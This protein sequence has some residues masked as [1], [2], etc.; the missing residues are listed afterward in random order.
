MSNI[1]NKAATD[2]EQLEETLLGP[3]YPY[4]KDINTPKDLGFSAGGSFDDLER[5]VDGLI[6][7][8]DVL[9]TGR[10]NASRTGRPLGNK[11]FL[12]TGGKCKDVDTGKLVDRYMYIN[13]VPDGDIP[14]ISEAMGRSF[15][16]FE[17]L[18][19]GILT[20]LGKINPMKFLQALTLGENPPCKEVTLEVINDNNYASKESHHILL[21]D[22]AQAEGFENMNKTNDNVKMPNDPIIQLYYL[23]LGLVIIY[24]LYCLMNKQKK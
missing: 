18:L 2:V 20:D 23:S 24:I 13:N 10:G 14:F 5:D 3:T 1:F 11:F 6:D 16:S 4:W 15:N 7:Y 17:G 9:V 21:A 12:P 22:L 19:P 8:V